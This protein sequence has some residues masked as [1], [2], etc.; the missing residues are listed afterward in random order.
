MRTV[1]LA[2][3]S[4]GNSTYIESKQAKILI[5]V[6]L[7]LKQMETRLNQI[8]VSGNEIDA[9]LLTHEHIDHLHGAKAFLKKYTNTKIYIPLFAKN[10]CIKEFDEL[11]KENIVYFTS[12]Q[13]TIK[14]MK[15]NCFILSHDSMF[16]LGYSVKFE[17]CK[18]S[19]ATDLGFISRDIINYLANSDVLFIES[20][21][22]ENLLFENPK[23]PA[24][25]K[26][27][28]A[29]RQGHLSNKDC[30]Y[31]LVQ[32]A[33]A[34]VKQVVLSHLSHEN[35]SPN[36]AYNTVRDILFK[37]NIIEGKNI[38]VDVAYQD[39]VGTLFYL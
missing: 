7:C 23:Y 3:G 4:K 18:V 26:K 30:A 6:G 21:H 19:Y 16:C 28:I 24:K 32:L 1:N 17:N 11:P 8:E 22:D 38:F 12:S 15:I 37:N 35:N 27:R 31:A 36:L 13:F 25:T 33:G 39:K 20:N 5:D 9:I 34:G 10:Y 14:D 2:S 29:S